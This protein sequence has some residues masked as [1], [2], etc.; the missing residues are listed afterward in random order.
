MGDEDAL[1][2]SARDAARDAME[3]SPAALVAGENPVIDF[4]GA[5][6]Y[7]PLRRGEAG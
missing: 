3:P 7:T 1:R 5:G 6:R 4:N 2:P